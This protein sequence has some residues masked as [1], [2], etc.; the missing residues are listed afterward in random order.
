MV[1]FQG[2]IPRGSDSGDGPLDGLAAS[3]SLRHRG[4]VHALPD[5]LPRVDEHGVGAR[6]TALQQAASCENDRERVIEGERDL[7]TLLTEQ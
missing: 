2:H 4:G 1:V 3:E 5:R 7:C 6:G